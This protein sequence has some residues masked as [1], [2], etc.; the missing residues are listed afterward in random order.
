VQN[1][2]LFMIHVQVS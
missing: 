2:S 1:S